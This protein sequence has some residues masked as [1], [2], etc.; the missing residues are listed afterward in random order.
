MTNNIF[1]PINLVEL[2]EVFND[3]DKTHDKAI[4]K[5][6]NQDSPGTSV[7]PNSVIDKV[8]GEID[9]A[10][11]E[12]DARDVILKGI[13]AKDRLKKYLSNNVSSIDEVGIVITDSHFRTAVMKLGYEIENKIRKLEDGV[14]FLYALKKSC[15]KVFFLNE[16]WQE[17]N[18]SF[19]NT[20]TSLNFIGCLF[21]HAFLYIRI[22]L[23]VYSTE[24]AYKEALSL[25]PNSSMRGIL[26]K[27]A[28]DHGHCMAALLYA[29][30]IYS[31]RD[32]ALH[33]FLI[34]TGLTNAQNGRRK[35]SETMSNAF[36]EIGFMF[37]NHYLSETIIDHVMK[38]LQIEKRIREISNE[39]YNLCQTTYKYDNIDA[40]RKDLVWGFSFVNGENGCTGGTG[41]DEILYFEEIYQNDPCKAFAM[42]I[43][44]YIAMKD[45][46]F[47]KAFNSLGKLLLGDYMNSDYETVPDVP[48]NNKRLKKAMNYLKNAVLFG[49]TDAMVSI[50]VYYYNKKKK[51]VKLNTSEEREMWYYLETAA[52]FE[53]K[54]AEAHLGELLMEKQ[55]YRE[56]RV[57]LEH[58][59]QMNNKVAVYSLGKL[60][61]VEHRFVQAIECY[62]KAIQLG[63]HDAA[64]N[65]AK[66]YLLNKRAECGE[67]NELFKTYTNYGMQL[68]SAHCAFFSP[69]IK[70]S[71]I[72]LLQ[73]LELS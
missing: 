59:A 47:P 56:A 23:P 8:F 45:F 19:R 58:A 62:E 14:H 73:K 49:N 33:Y 44:Y 27:A 35:N 51:G 4:S 13:G 21:M 30:D 72:D 34:A 40:L 37:E 20:K 7:S 63:Y 61:E 39:R 53:E 48:I 17:L 16:D 6:L 9:T 67:V 68:I 52:S 43:Y 26:L 65:L 69:E 28:A 15:N 32:R 22:N 50:A 24:R 10:S 2:C 54:E 41:E 36:W 25:Y 31:D 66:L 3:Y 29:N 11:V 46:S 38:I 18:H 55:R 70:K 60:N 12:G 42:K 64:F 71:C 5:L 1:D 57:Y